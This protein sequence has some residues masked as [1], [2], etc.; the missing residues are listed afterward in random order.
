[1]QT[2]AYRRLLIVCNKDDK[3]GGQKSVTG[4]G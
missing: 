2:K 4:R 1:M 3:A